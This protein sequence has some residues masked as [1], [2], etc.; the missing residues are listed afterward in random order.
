M[1]KVTID[2]VLANIS[3]HL[4]L[5]KETEH[6]LLA[7]IRTHL[8]D[9]VAKAIVKGEDEAARVA[10]H[11]FPP[12]GGQFL[13]IEH[14]DPGLARLVDGDGVGMGGQEMD[15]V[16]GPD[17]ARGLNRWQL[18]HMDEGEGVAGM[19]VQHGLE[20]GHEGLAVV[21]GGEFDMDDER[22]AP[23]QR[24]LE[25]DLDLFAF[26]GNRNLRGHGVHDVAFGGVPDHDFGHGA[27]ARGLKLLGEA[28][29][30]F[31]VV[32]YIS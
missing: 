2:Q 19:A 17:Q 27:E 26:G 5:S 15:V 21:D 24:R 32:A 20:L 13:A 23:F 29:V 25:G 6:E 31:G 30:I 7:E 11:Q 28:P 3:L 16:V 18:S 22:P 12:V 9:A 1:G 8:E 14:V 10:D 4:H